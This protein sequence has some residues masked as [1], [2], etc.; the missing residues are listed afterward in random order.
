[1]K[2]FNHFKPKLIGS[3]LLVHPH[4]QS[5][6]DIL[7]MADSPEEVPMFLMEQNIP[8]QLQDWKL[9]SS[10]HTTNWSPLISFMPVITRL[11]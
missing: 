6:I 3:V 1:M 5:S 7:V 2:L 4:K 8:Y 9:F 11:N 10:K